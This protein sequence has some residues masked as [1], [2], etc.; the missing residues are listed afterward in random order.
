MNIDQIFKIPAI[1]SG[2]NKRKLH[3][4]PD[5]DFLD[6]YRELNATPEQAESSSSGSKS[7]RRNV[8]IED[9]EDG[10]DDGVEYMGYD[11]EEDEGRFYG[12][13]LTEEQQQIMDLMDEVDEEEV[14]TKRTQSVTWP[15]YIATT[16][17]YIFCPLFLSKPEAMDLTGVKRMILKFEKAINKNQ[18]LRMKFADDPTKYVD[19]FISHSIM[20][21]S[22]DQLIFLVFD[23]HSRFMESEADLDEEIK[24]LLTLAQVPHLYPDVAKLGTIPSLL[25]LLSHENT[26]IAIDA[27]ELLNELTDEDVGAA[28]ADN[29]EDEDAALEGVRLE[30]QMLELLI[31]N[32]SRMD[33][34]EP[35]D[36]QG[37]FNTLGIMENLTGLDP[38]LSE[39]IVAETELL[40][41]LLKRIKVK[42]FDSNKQYASEIIAILL[43]SS[44]GG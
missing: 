30:N 12:G 27:I 3:A 22:P 5:Q 17:R 10:A 35:A 37:V 29:E 40:P 26:D 44:R 4:N 32:L 16:D 43:Q 19:L 13:G 42:A 25:S 41:W 9:E 28:A 8:T 33:E 2:K 20:R 36:K 11:E 14:S 1:P 15:D 34:N 38:K 21:V 24:H 18:E 6:K 39:R 31:Q 23:P 7:K